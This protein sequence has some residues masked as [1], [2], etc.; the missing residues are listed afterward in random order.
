MDDRLPIPLR[1]DVH[2]LAADEARSLRRALG[3]IAF[4]AKRRA[5]PATAV[6]AAWAGDQRAL[7]I[8]ERAGQ[9]PTMQ[10]DLPG[11]SI[12][13]SFQSLAPQSALLA[14]LGRGL[15]VDLAGVTSAIVPTVST[16]PQP[17]FIPEGLP[18]PVVALE[19]G[20]TKLGPRKKVLV[21]SAITG[22]LADASVAETVVGTVLSDA[23]SRSI[24]SVGF[25]DQAPDDV[26]PGGLFY[27]VTPLA[28]AAAGSD[29]MVRDTAALFG[30]I[31]DAGVD[32]S[33]C[34][35]VA[36][37]RQATALQ[38]RSSPKFVAPILSSIALEDGAIAVVATQGVASSMTQ[39][40]IE[41]STNVALHFE[42]Q[43]PQPIVGPDGPAAPVRSAF[44]E[45]Y[46]GMRVRG[47]ACWVAQPGSVALLTGA[48]WP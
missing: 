1:P 19:F 36:S 35:V 20:S 24:D 34:V 22:E 38:M 40:S 25:S 46:I 44:Q 39:P 2:A 33:Q 41:A 47:F 29:A 16:R 17:V 42:D 9:E 27:G 43:N 32:I 26:S 11:R 13:L 18:A 28:P 3:A 6:K 30:A 45:N 21:L 37:A 14:V 8:V 48:Q 15:Q 31:A 5:N 7:A 10:G 4:A 12:V 23:V